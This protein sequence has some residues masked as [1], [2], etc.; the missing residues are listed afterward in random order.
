MSES[1]PFLV[2][3]VYQDM[4]KIVIDARGYSTTTGRYIRKLVENLEI[5]EAD[6]NDREY[7]VLLF[8]DE[9]DKYQPKNPRFS[10]Q[11]AEFAHYSLVPEQIKFCRFLKTMKADLVHFTMPQQPVF[12]LGAHITTVHDLTLLKVFPGNRNKFVYKL[13]QASGNFVFKRIA[14]TSRAIITPSQAT[15]DEYLKLLSPDP[16][17]SNLVARLDLAKKMVVTPESAD[18]I[19]EKPAPYPALVDKSYIMYVGQQSNYKNLRRLIESHQQLLTTHPQLQLVFVGKLGEY[20]KQTRSWAE[21]QNFTNI[22][23]TGFVEDA[24]LAWLYQNC[25]AYV[26]PSLMEGFGLPG[27]EAMANDAP[28]VSSNATS[29]PEVHGDA[30][31][32]FDPTSVE[33]MT[34][35]ISDVLTDKTLR[36]KLIKNGY[37]QL[38]KYSW[39]RMAQQTLAIYVDSLRS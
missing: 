4:K 6:Q 27:L 33:D 3:L 17:R 11:V 2:L 37:T 24:Q 15:K 13:K 5:L 8:A 39:H 29:L 20:G 23:F 19:A 9:F 34:R 16:A 28:V 38:K 31:H 25:Q 10:K 36:T 35:A 7:V 22:V 21:Q 14:N 32:Y 26:F 1:P 30:A 12:Y 18:P